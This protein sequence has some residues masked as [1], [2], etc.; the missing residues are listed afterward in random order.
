MKFLQGFLA[1]LAVGSAVLYAAFN[2]MV[3]GLLHLGMLAMGGLIVAL[4]VFAL[5]VWFVNWRYY[6]EAK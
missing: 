1:L 2:Y 5:L 4:D 6:P 3:E